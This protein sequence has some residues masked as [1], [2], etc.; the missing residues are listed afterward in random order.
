MAVPRGAGADVYI[1]VGSVAYLLEDRWLKN[2]RLRRGPSGRTTYRMA[3][4]ETV[5]AF[6]TRVQTAYAE[7]NPVRIQP[8]DPLRAIHQLT[9]LPWLP[10]YHSQH[11]KSTR[12]EA[13][14]AVFPKGGHG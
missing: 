13:T 9:S 10:A 5:A 11:V 6:T 2:V 7:A 12:C 3:A 1:M 8:A 4:G 14:F